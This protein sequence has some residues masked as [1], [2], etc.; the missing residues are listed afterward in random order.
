M[1]IRA[2]TVAGTGFV[3]FVGSRGR[4]TNYLE[5][6]CASL[7]AGQAAMALISLDPAKFICGSIRLCIRCVTSPEIVAVS[8]E[9]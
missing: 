3:L 2:V 4:V 1:H 5:G 6:K 8:Y 7:C 9:E